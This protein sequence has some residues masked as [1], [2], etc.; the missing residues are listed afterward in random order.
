MIHCISQVA[1]IGGDNMFA[2][3]F[4]VAQAL[5]EEHPED[6]HLLTTL[7]LDFRNLGEDVYKFHLKQ[8]VPTIE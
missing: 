3:G 8:R 5:A 1:S 7:K 2:D 6:Y 4:R